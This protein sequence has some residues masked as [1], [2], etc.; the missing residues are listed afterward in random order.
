MYCISCGAKVPEQVAYCPSCGAATA[1]T[2]AEVG[3]MSDDSSSPSPSN[4]DTPKTPPPPPTD[5][6]SS[7]YGM[8]QQ[9]TYTPPNPYY[10]PT[11][12]PPVPRPSSPPQPQQH[13][14][15]G[16]IVGLTI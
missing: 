4:E 14:R 15:V 12:P 1:Y 5:Y 3:I 7:P 10:V 13:T 9:N 6:G 16:L 8:P 2:V 11:Q